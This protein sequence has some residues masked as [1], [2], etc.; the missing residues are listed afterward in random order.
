[1]P[2]FTVDGTTDGATETTNQACKFAPELSVTIN[3]DSASTLSFNLAA[4][5]QF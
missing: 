4:A 2:G 5:G 1:M 3:M